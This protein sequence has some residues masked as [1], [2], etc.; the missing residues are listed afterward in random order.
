MLK[1]KPYAP[2]LLVV[3]GF[4]IYSNILDAPFV[5]D[6]N[7]YITDNP[8]VGSL[9]NLFDMRDARYVGFVT[10]ALNNYIGGG[11]FGLH[12]TNVAIH[13]ANSVLLYLLISALL[14]A[15]VAKGFFGPDE[16]PLVNLDRLALCIALVFVAH[17]TQIYAVTYI[18]QRFTSLATLFYLGAIIFYLKSAPDISGNGSN[19]FRSSL[20]YV[21]SLILT[22][23][24]MKTKEI[25]FTL[26]V[27]L[28]GVEFG[29]LRRES[30]AKVSV[31]RII[32]FI[33]T[34]L[35]IPLGVIGVGI[36]GGTENAVGELMMQQK[37]KDIAAVSSYEY[38][39]GQSMV[40]ITYIRMLL[41]PGSECSACDFS[42]GKSF[43]E[44]AIF[45]ASVTLLIVIAATVYLF[46]RSVARRNGYLL[47]IS[48][49][50]LWFFLTLSVESS[51]I[52]IQDIIVRHRTYLPGVGFITSA[53]TAFF[54]LVSI[55]NRRK[56][57]N[58]SP[59]YIT[60]IFVLMIS[61]ITHMHNR[62][63]T[64]AIGLNTY[65]AELEPCSSS[66]HISLAGV[67][68]S[69]GRWKAAH[70]EYRKAVGIEPDRVLAWSNL[71]KVSMRLGLFDEA[72]EEYEIV[73][74]L[75]PG[76]FNAHY[77]IGLLYLKKGLPDESDVELAQAL[78]LS[79]G[80]EMVLKLRAL[81]LKVRTGEFDPSGLKIRMSD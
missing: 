51:V 56:R 53:V 12:I 79:P 30:C 71:A 15:L 52:P 78:R 57:V 11:L 62:L 55:I 36:L 81:L 41:I 43:F 22:V 68:A 14:R 20:C 8:W 64:D 74:K 59:F 19:R 16:K 39:L 67:Y 73:L 3:V 5:L 77:S 33:L 9:G 42:I 13:V 65:F 23:I 49:G 75:E 58:I 21:F 34:M 54:L 2:I 24:A 66:H 35:I 32:P 29:L 60:L 31:V 61:V 26:P 48:S 76:N 46:I 38:L 80:N 10:F 6:D 4:A 45:S 28:M 27:V 1:V 69:E 17:P 72:I 70:T 40:I 7:V 25:S 63:W 44:P 50:I 18:T 37:L 47:L